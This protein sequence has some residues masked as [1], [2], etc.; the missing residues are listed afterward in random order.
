MAQ[1]TIIIAKIK[2]QISKFSGITSKEFPKPKRRLNVE[3]LYNLL[4][5][6]KTGLKT[7][8]CDTQ[9]FQLCFNFW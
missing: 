7:K 9:D 5:P 8:R 6:D 4:F 2:A 3:D 1:D